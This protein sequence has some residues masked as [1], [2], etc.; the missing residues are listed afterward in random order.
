MTSASP[1]TQSS[2]AHRTFRDPAGWVE[3]R[4]DG[5]YRFIQPAFQAELLAFLGSSLADT[6]VSEGRLVASERLADECPSDVS[7]RP[8]DASRTD[9][10]ADPL[11]VLRHPLVPFVSYPWEWC[12][13]Q[14]LAAAELTLTLNRDLIAEGWI[15]KDATPLNILFRGAKPVLVDVASVARL[16]PTRPI[17]YAY[18]QFVRTFLLPMLAHTELGWPLRSSLLRRDGLEPE[19]LLAALPL[20]KRL[21]QPALSSVT[22]PSLL[23]RTR[24]RQAADAASAKNTPSTQDPELVQHILQATSAKLLKQ[25]RRA[26]P[27]PRPSSWTSY[28]GTAFH[29]SDA[30]H[31]AKRAFIAEALGTSRPRHVL[32]IGANAGVYSELAADTG[33]SVVAVDTDLQTLDRLC[34]RLQAS[35][36]DILP[37]VV[38]LANPT[39]GIGWLNRESSAFLE[40]AAG[41]FDGVIMLAVLHHLL[42]HDHVPLPA[43]AQLIATLTTRIL[44]IEWVPPTDVMFRELVR[45]REAIFASI[46]E[47]AF[48]AHFAAYFATVREHSLENGRILFHLEKR[49]GS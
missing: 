31:A 32:D 24:P 14:W 19:D 43:V 12:P 13:A 37:L 17:W 21:R 27:A 15:L 5:A 7:E 10:V 28:S 18:S 4:N 33:A 40:R 3:L 49:P 6:L 16:D 1:S 35:G 41:H 46:T 22:L 36:K 47:A 39:P 45:G 8:S 2:V 23:S 9:D 38:D 11:L 42:L 26:M 29:Y 30:D 25:M 44:L 20:A 34:G 48:R